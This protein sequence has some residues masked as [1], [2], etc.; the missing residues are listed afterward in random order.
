MT[1]LGNAVLAL[2]ASSQFEFVM[3]A[4]FAK[5]AVV[6]RIVSA[7]PEGASVKLYTRWRPE[8]I[9]AGVSDTGVLAILE[10]RGGVVY[11]HDRLHAKFYRNE[12]QVLLGSAN[13]TGTA[14]GWSA[15]P[16]I[17][18]LTAVQKEAVD[19]VELQLSVESIHATPEIA[20]EV[21]DIAR[22]LQMPSFVSESLAEA[23]PG[24]AQ[25]WF[26]RFRIPAD[27]FSAYSRGLASLTARSAAAAVADLEVLDLPHGLGKEQ[28]YLLVAHRLRQQPLVVAVDDY[29]KQPRRFGEVR[30]KIDQLTAIGREDASDAWQTLMRWFL[31]FL[32]DRYTRE[33]PRHSELFARQMNPMG[34]T[35]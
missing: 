5:E 1:E 33:V 27:L 9:A 34:T 14:L 20:L 19:Q 28:F 26:P 12:N 11:L 6:S 17:E 31:E 29:L 22:S 18:L 32:P 23:R 24:P 21:D 13:L 10:A 2:A 4:P 8:E 25:T 30:D 7:L 16:N 15:K 3:C 35:S